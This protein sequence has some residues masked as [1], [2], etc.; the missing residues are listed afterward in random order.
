MDKDLAKKVIDKMFYE[1]WNLQKADIADQ[2]FAK[3][4]E[5]HYSV[6]ILNDINEFKALL[7]HWFIGIPDLKHTI[8]DYITEGNKVVARWHGEGTHQGNF[9]DISPT[10]KL[11]YY[12]GI[13]ILELLPDGKIIKAWVYNDLTDSLSKLK[14]I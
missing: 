14:G 1:M 2:L 6:H 12:G 3:D 11:F 7:N 5:I 13:T 4:F 9:I 8:D 10:D